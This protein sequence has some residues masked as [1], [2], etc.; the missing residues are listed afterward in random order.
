MLLSVD[1][2][3]NEAQV[4][5]LCDGLAK[6]NA[7]F[8]ARRRVRR[9]RL[10]AAHAERCVAVTSLQRFARGHFGRK[11]ARAHREE[12]QK[13]WP[14]IQR[15]MRGAL[16]RKKVKRLRA[17]RVLQRAWRCFNA[18]AELRGLKLKTSSLQHC[19]SM[20]KEYERNGRLYRIYRRVCTRRIINDS[21]IRRK[22]GGGR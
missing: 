18:R 12:F 10:S 16:T 11:Y 3:Q 9:I 21:W 8:L 19:A 13:S 1:K 4:Q 14:V 2:V 20:K 6:D 7:G 15:V 5:R 17:A 22:K